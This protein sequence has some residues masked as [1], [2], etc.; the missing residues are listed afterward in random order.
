MLTGAAAIANGREQVRVDL[1]GAAPGLLAVDL[2]LAIG[3]PPQHAPWFALGPGGEV[4]RTAQT[5]L[6]LV[7]E[8][9]G[10]GGLLGSSIRLPLYLDLAFAEARLKDVS[11]PSGRPDEVRVAVEARPGIAELR[12]ADIDPHR[13]DDFSTAPPTRP[14]EIVRIP[15]V[16]ISGA[17]RIEVANGD[18]TTLD[19]DA[20]DIEDLAVKRVSSTEITASLLTSLLRD[21]RLDVE[22]AGLGLGLPS[23]LS[24]TVAG[25]LEGVAPAVDEVLV[26]LLSALG[27]TVGE[28]DV[29]VHGASCGRA[30]LVQ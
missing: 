25:L 18:F 16:K 30:V 7:L 10:P 4:V 11:C 23:G 9:G 21:L 15:L 12:I 24:G 8:V 14:A 20:R 19:F 1:E 3:E 22:I 5:R 2:D 13:M 17:A 27:V 26:T 6:R 29:R 28:A